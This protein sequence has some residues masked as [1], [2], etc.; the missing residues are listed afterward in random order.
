[1]DS[2]SPPGVPVRPTQ[3]QHRATHRVDS[4]CGVT[5]GCAAWGTRPAPARAAC[6]SDVGPA[7]PLPPLCAAPWVCYDALCGS[8]IQKM[9]AAAASGDTG[10][11]V[12]GMILYARGGSS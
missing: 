5:A 9:G 8:N 11:G 3:T 7:P 1:M 4:R 2:N 6:L 12:N 10:V